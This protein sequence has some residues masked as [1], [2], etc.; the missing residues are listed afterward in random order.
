MKLEY[1]LVCDYA[2]LDMAGKHNYIGLFR[3]INIDKKVNADCLSPQF[4]ICAQ[5]SELGA[6]HH[7]LELNLESPQKKII[8]INKGSVEISDQIE[9]ETNFA[10]I[11]PVKPTILDSTGFW[12]V[13]LT[14]DKEVIT[15]TQFKVSH[16]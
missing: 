16:L 5:I 8:E 2:F 6:G 4:F 13:T 14:I 12:K 1:G 3:N 7:S 10:L 9:S 15:I 11:M